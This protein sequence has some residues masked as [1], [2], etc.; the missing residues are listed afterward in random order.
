M[1]T[2]DPDPEAL[3]RAMEREG[4]PS[5]YA[6]DVLELWR[7]PRAHWRPCCGLLCD[8]CVMAL[9]RVVDRLHAE[10]RG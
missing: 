5:D 3:A 10:R 9:A 1:S 6:P 4:V 2:P 7:T 8:P